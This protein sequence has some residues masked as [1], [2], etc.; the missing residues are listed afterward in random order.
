[1]HEKKKNE[2][3]AKREF[4]KRIRESKEKAMKENEEKAL[5]QVMF[6]TQTINEQGQLVNVKDNASTVE[7]RL[8]SLGSSV[9]TADI[10]KELFE[11][12]NIVT[13]K[14]TDHGLQDILKNQELNES[15]KEGEGA[16]E[17]KSSEKSDESLEKLRDWAE[18]VR[19]KKKIKIVT[20]RMSKL[21]KY[22]SKN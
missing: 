18:S 6:F 19:N 3:K 21:I 9:A 8:E 1:M 7:K 11:G 4:D 22:N 15:G 12:D 16:E 20:P 14:K 5:N 13:S 2:E 17:Q 10:R